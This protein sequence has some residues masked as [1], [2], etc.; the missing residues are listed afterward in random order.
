M[1][2]QVKVRAWLIVAGV[3]ILTSACGGGSKPAPAGGPSATAPVA[4][5]ANLSLDKNAY[6]VFSDADAGADPAVSAEQGGKGFKGEGWETNTSFDLIGDPRAV[7]GGTLRN[8]IGAF[9]GTLRMAGPEWNT[10]MNYMI[11]QLVYETLLTLDPTTLQYVPLVASHWQISPDKLTYRFRID[12]NARFS[13]GSPVTADDVVASWE[14]HTDKTL[15]DLYFFTE[16]TKL[17]KPIVES[18]YIVRIKAKALRWDNFFTAA[19]MRVFPAKILRTFNGAGY[20]KDYNFKLIPGTGPYL[21]TDADIKKGSSISLRRRNDYWAANHRFNVG[22]N[23]FDEIRNIVVRD[24]KLAFEQ[25]KK[26][27]L[28]LYYVN[29]SKEWIEDLNFPDVQRGVVLKRK[30][31]NNYPPS[32]QFMA[33]NTRRKPWD[34]VRVRKAFALLFN[35]DQLIKT[36]FFNEYVPLNS[37]FPGTVYENPDNPKNLYDPQQ[38]LKLLADAGWKDRD[39]EGRLVKD[40]RPLQIE[41]L[42]DDKGHEKWMTVYQEDLRKVG[43][44]LNLRLVTPETSFKMEMQRQFDLIHSAWGVGS[45]F[46]EPRDNYHSSG[47]DVPNNNNI[48]GMKNKRIYEICD[49]YDAEFDLNKRV[50]LIRELDGIVANEYHYINNWYAASER[51]AFWNKFGMPKGTFSRI[52]NFDGSFAPGIPQLWWVDP[53]KTQNLERAIRDKSSKL[54]APPVEDHYWEQFSKD[55][56]NQLGTGQMK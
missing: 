13:D 14:F 38:A 2:D 24:Q 49:Q 12:P 5:R 54:E 15:Q 55:P 8:S 40:G 4:S 46:P 28:D 21:V 22:Q 7:K 25:F 51:V 35:R 20:L 33:F 37:F 39:S 11:S 50:A 27:D 31:F 34:D 43:I 53:E 42:Y 18:K 45:P 41:L 16:Y 17:E 9:P 26:G 3:A 23:N 48:T 19:G 6:P 56:K 10:S 30:V 52:G 29:I 36:L 1:R 47:A 44:G 32:T